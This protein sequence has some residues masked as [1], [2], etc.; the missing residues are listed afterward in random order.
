MTN[1]AARSGSGSTSGNEATTSLEFG[2]HVTIF[3]KRVSVGLPV[4]AI[5]KFTAVFGSGC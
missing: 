3:D 1:E 4:D 5:M 2:R